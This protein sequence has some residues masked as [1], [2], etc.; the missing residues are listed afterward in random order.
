VPNYWKTWIADGFSGKNANCR[1]SSEIAAVPGMANQ[2]QTAVPTEDV[3]TRSSTT[4]DQ[5]A[6]KVR[7]V[8]RV[9]GFVRPPHVARS[10]EPPYSD[11]AGKM[12]YH[13]VVT[14]SI[15]VNRDGVPEEIHILN[16]LGAGLDAN[17]VRTVERW[18]FKPA[19]KDGR[20]VAVR[21]AIEVDFHR[22]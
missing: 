16:P 7:A 20:P 3:A 2:S 1:F 5:A 8:T 12:D 22:Y 21:I 17:A 13:S 11:A 15:I 18:R 14:L 4:S 19:E 6:E 10:P 9:G